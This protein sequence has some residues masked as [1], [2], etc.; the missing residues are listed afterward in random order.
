MNKKLAKSLVIFAAAASLAVTSLTNTNVFAKS[1]SQKLKDAKEAQKNAEDNVEAAKDKISN[2]KETQSGLQSNL[3]NLN[4][5]LTLISD[6]IAALEQQ[7]ADKEAEIEETKAQLKQAKADKKAQYNFIKARICTIYEQG[8]ESYL[9]LLLDTTDFAD[10]LNRATYVERVNQYDQAML[11]KY[12]ELVAE[13]KAQKEKLEEEKAELDA[14]KEDAKTEQNKVQ[15]LVN[16]TKNS[17][18]AYA[19][20]IS[21]AEAAALQYEAKLVAAKNT[22]SSLKSQLAA[23]EELARKSQQMAKRSLSE[24]TIGHGERELLGAIIQ[25]EAGGEPYEGK[26]AVGAVIMNRVMS[27][28]FPSTITGVVYQ[29]NQFEPVASG[30]LAIV[31][32]Q[33][34]NATCLKAAD[35]VMAGANNIGECLFFRTIVP[36]IKGTIIGHHVFYLYWTGKY[37][38]YGTKEDS[39]SN[40]SSEATGAPGSSSKEESSEEAESSEESSEEESSEE[41]SEEESSSS[42][43][44]KDDEDKDDDSNDDDDG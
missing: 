39:L 34:A 20:E 41:S 26:I 4:N 31:L 27:G 21:A 32:A 12:K 7:Q 33:G 44:S 23:E 42:E 13:T 43:E 25:C 40:P 6:T 14:L 1:T 9:A 15:E 36:G 30:R 8:N 3:N 10:F 37:S 24:V 18:T 5:K 35:A 28:A 11:D 38:G 17:I 22:V 19:G 2:L 29:A 16:T